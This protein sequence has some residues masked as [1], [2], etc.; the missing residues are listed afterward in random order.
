VPLYLSG[1]AAVKLKLIPIES[2]RAIYCTSLDGLA[3]D[4]ITFAP[5]KVVL[6]VPNS[7]IQRVA[8]LTVYSPRKEYES[9]QS[10]AS[11]KTN[12]IHQINSTNLTNSTIAVAHLKHGDKSQCTTG[13]MSSCDVILGLPGMRELGLELRV[14]DQPYVILV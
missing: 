8:Y 4:L 13:S 9:E 10:Q 7:T 5:I 3:L 1:H 11:S 6:Q 12:A 14:S 2:A